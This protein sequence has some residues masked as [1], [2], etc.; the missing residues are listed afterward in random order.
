VSETRGGK[1]SPLKRK[2]LRNPG[3]SVRQARQTLIDDEWIPYVFVAVLMVFVACFE[4]VQWYTNL[5]PQPVPLS[6]VA[7]IAVGFCTYKYF[8]VRRRNR[9]LR[10]G[11]EGEKA[12]G[13]Y[14][15]DLR[16][17]GCRVFHD[18][19]GD[20]FN[21]DHVVISPR[22]IFVIETKTY[23]KSTQGRG[24]V[25]FDGER[26]LVN[27]MEPERN[28]VTQVRALAVWLRDLLAESTGRRFPIRCAVVF[29]G[30]F[31]ENRAKRPSDVW[32]LN[33][34]GLPAF[35][36]HEPFQ[37]KPEDVALISSRIITHIQGV[38]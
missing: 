36:E 22:G 31:V 28:A 18:V 21:L 32:V 1:R 6:V 7:L 10:L 13:Q 17:Q 27:G 4:W 26:I 29:P 38:A 16:R 30:W 15:E 33:P 23:S 24:V 11:E 20:G 34:K 8:T 5:P 3:E 35:I 14:L 37:L 19:V 12:V 2:P 25:E 9:V